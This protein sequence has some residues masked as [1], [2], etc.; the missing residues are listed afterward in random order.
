MADLLV[1]RAGGNPF[2]LEEAF[3]DLVE[4]G[5]LRRSN[6]SWELAVGADELAVPALVQGAL[7]A[8]LDRLD[9]R[10]REVLCS[11]R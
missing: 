7:Q 9:P 8:R 2:F 11:P 4:R 1:E 5:A 6:G 10:T 3:R